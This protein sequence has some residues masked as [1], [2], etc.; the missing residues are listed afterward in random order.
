MERLK[1][2]K[3]RHVHKFDGSSEDLVHHTLDEELN[4]VI[5][6]RAHIMK[7]RGGLEEVWG[8]RGFDEKLEKAGQRMDARR[9][10]SVLIVDEYHFLTEQNKDKLFTQF[11]NRE[12]LQMVLIANRIDASD[13][14]RV[15]MAKKQSGDDF[16]ELIETRLGKRSVQ[17]SETMQ[18]QK[19]PPLIERDIRRFLHTAGLLFGDEARSLRLVPSLHN[20]LNVED[21]D[22][23]GL[24]RLLMQQ[25][26]ILV[27]VVL[28][29]AGCSE[30]A[31][32]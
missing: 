4:E 12:D 5:S 26:L 8:D 25:A 1:T 14:E 32:M 19:V 28:L 9:G 29:V 23:D 17:L 6:V 16:A 11:C 31:L 24:V 20:A 7:P 15:A 10:R 3:G 22:K 30:D 21:V 27:Y 2:E 13:R 18:K